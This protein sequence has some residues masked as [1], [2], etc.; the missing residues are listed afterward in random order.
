MGFKD[1][2]TMF[3]TDTSKKFKFSVILSLV[4]FVVMLIVF[5]QG[6]ISVNQ[7]YTYNLDNHMTIIYLSFVA[8]M[9][10]FMIRNYSK[11]RFFKGT[12]LILVKIIVLLIAAYFLYVLNF[13]RLILPFLYINDTLFILA[14]A[15]S[16]TFIK[17]IL[18]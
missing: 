12:F 8:G 3:K 18:G 16:I 17:L 9:L 1:L 15:V 6:Y 5:M 11:H 13:Q 7:E 10:A 4:A 14:N 2:F